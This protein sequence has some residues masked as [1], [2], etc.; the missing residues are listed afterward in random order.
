MLDIEYSVSHEGDKTGISL[1]AG[2][3]DVQVRLPSYLRKKLSEELSE[4]AEE[5]SK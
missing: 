2:P 4:L 1:T 3:V 5:I